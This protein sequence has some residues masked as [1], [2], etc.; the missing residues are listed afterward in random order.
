MNDDTK[1]EQPSQI[2]KADSDSMLVALYDQFVEKSHELFELGKEISLEACEKSMESAKQQMAEAGSFTNEQG[3]AF[4]NYL[5]RDLDHTMAD[6]HQLGVDLKDG[7]NPARL[8]AGALSSLAKLLHASGGV[9]TR[10]SE[11]TEDALEYKTGEITMACTLTC[12]T[13]GH[14]IHYNKTSVILFCPSCNGTTFR[15]GY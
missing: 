5:R 12:S 14:K 15:K 8:G 3:E 11:R 4:K 1:S 2:S 7:V 13:C 10:L 9:L 6:A